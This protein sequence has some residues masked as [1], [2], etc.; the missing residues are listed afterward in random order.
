MAGT[1]L[2]DWVNADASQSACN[3][4]GLV[5]SLLDVA[6][7]VW[8]DVCSNRL[9]G[10]TQFGQHPIVRLYVY[11]IFYLTWGFEPLAQGLDLYHEASTAMRQMIEKL[12]K[13]Q[14]C[15]SAPEK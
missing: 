12:G 8:E 14:V 11:Q 15:E 5:Y 4:S 10:V 9:E 7:R 1:T 2:R 6:D 13:E 3:P